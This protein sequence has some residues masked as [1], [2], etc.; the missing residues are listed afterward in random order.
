MSTRAAY[1]LAAERTTTANN[2]R[3][4]L[5]ELLQPKE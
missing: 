2:H 4:D 3:E 5:M 1:E